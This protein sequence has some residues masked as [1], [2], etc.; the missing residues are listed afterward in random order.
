MQPLTTRVAGFCAGRPG[1]WFTANEAAAALGAPVDAVRDT[2]DVLVKRGVNGTLTY[3][4]GSTNA[5]DQTV[6]T[7]TLSQ[8]GSVTPSVSGGIG[9][10]EEN[11][12]FNTA[13]NFSAAGLYFDAHFFDNENVDGPQNIDQNG[14]WGHFWPTNT[15]A[16]SFTW[17][18]RD[19]SALR[20]YAA[21]SI[22][23]KP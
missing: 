8:P 10:V 2:L 15:S 22:I 9:F 4:T 6:G 17:Q 3:D 5:G 12:E 13:T 16:I 18:F 21:H 11:H 19:T 14:G 23:F 20:T 7:G 1:L